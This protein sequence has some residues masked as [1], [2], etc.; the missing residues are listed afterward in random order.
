VDLTRHAAVLW[1]FRAVTAAGVVLAVLLA[2]LA[3]YQPTWD[4]G[5]ALR[6][7][8]FET[9]EANSSILV[10]QPGFP[11]GRVTLPTKELGEGLTTTEG[12][13]AVTP[14]APPKDQVEFADPARLAGLADLYSKF[15]TSD[16]VLNRVPGR[17]TSGQI[18]ASPFQ[19]SQG[20]LVLPVIQLTSAAGSEADAR[21]LNVQVFNSLRAVLAKQQKA[22]DIAT[23]K[24]VEVKVI[25]APEATLTAGRKH[26]GSILAFLL[27][28]LGTVAVAH[29]LAGVRDR[30]DDEDTLLPVE[31]WGGTPS[32][33]LEPSLVG[34]ER[35]PGMRLDW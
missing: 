11:E 3:A 12:D 17:P 1:R 6:A 9:W 27:C 35:S 2:I 30:G 24:R 25:D 14:S 31:T 5:P 33:E 16:E 28:M 18:Q 32:D 20:G 15:L 8:G 13:P 4:G 23:G 21:K 19:S 10:T 34:D 7:R 22:N 29:L 26:T